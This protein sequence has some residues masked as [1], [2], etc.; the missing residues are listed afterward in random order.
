[1]SRI[2]EFW[3]AR[4]AREQ[5]LLAAL[6]AL[7]FGMVW[8]FAAVGPLLERAD[9]NKQRRDAEAALLQRLNR[10]GSRMPALPAPRLRSD[11][12]LLLL[13]NGSIRDAGLS[14]FLQ[15]AAADGETRVRLRLVDAPFPAVSAWLAT[16]AS[17]EG[18]RAVS[19]DIQRG[20]APGA[21]QV[22]LLLERGQ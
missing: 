4:S 14:T 21:T 20:S 16:L 2:A 3:R 5:A 11:A 8:Y 6:A 19:A 10:V 15:E 1:M 17:Q 7:A 9:V 18:V 12:S 22:S 13:V